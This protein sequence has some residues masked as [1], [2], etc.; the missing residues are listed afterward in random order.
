VQVSQKNHNTIA[1]SFYF[2]LTGNAIY[3]RGA[4][5]VPLSLFESNVSKESMEK[6]LWSVKAAGMNM[7]R[8]WGGGRYLNDHFYYLCDRMG[9]MIWQEMMFSCALYPSDINF[10]Q[11]IAEEVRQ[12]MI[13]V[14]NHPSVVMIGFNNENENSFEWFQ[15]AKINP[16]RYSDDYH[17]LLIEYMRQIL[18]EIMPETVNFV[19]S[20]PSNG[21]WERDPIYRKRWGS[22]SSVAFGDIHFYNYDSN[23]INNKTVYPAAKFV[24]EYGFMSLPSYSVYSSFV[25]EED[26][27]NPLEM[28]KFRTRHQFGL[29]QMFEQMQMHFW[30]FQCNHSVSSL[31]QQISGQNLPSFIYLSQLQ[32]ALIYEA[33][34]VRWRREMA[35]NST[36]GILYWQ[37]NDVW[38]GTSWS[39]INADL[40]WKMLHSSLRNY[41][42]PFSIMVDVTY[43]GSATGVSTIHFYASNH[44]LH[45]T[46]VNVEISLIPYSAQRESDRKVIFA[47]NITAGSQGYMSLHNLFV[48]EAESTFLYTAITSRSGEIISFVSFPSEIKDARLNYNTSIT[49]TAVLS[50]KHG[51][52]IEYSSDCPRGYHSMFSVVLS[53]SNGISLL[54]SLESILDIIFIENAVTVFPWESRVVPLCSREGLRLSEINLNLVVTWLQRALDVTSKSFMGICDGST[55]VDYRKVM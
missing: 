40:S 13:S 9:I 47:K 53:S 10:T 11:N 38:A 7:I 52:P 46:Q 54:A 42:S 33:A 51:K 50:A 36:M 37:L 15:E 31:L 49:V 41:F 39:S 26:L 45:S 19:D 14:L 55:S 35:P 32:Q 6:L 17:T 3:S 21:V 44:K 18:L 29:A 30:K 16:Q 27:E 48:E 22:T 5:L 24:S 1:E 34:T 8:V 25:D 2:R 20:S 12:H 28:L 23:M 4:N 43:G